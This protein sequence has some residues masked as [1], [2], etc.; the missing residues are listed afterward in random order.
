MPLIQQPSCNTW[1]PRW[2]NLMPL[3]IKSIIIILKTNSHIQSH[4]D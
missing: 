4:D 1:L 3:T 2:R